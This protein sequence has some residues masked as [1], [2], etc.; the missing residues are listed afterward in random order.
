L[1]ARGK[2]EF[3]GYESLEAPARITAIIGD[4]AELE[5]LAAGAKAEVVLDQTPFYAESGGQVGDHGA[6]YSEAGEK[7][8]V[9]FETYTPVPGLSVHKVKVT[10]AMAKGDAV[11]AKV[12]PE[13]RQ[14]TM[15]NHTATHL[16]H[17]ALRKVL[18]NHVKQAGSV[19]E[20]GRLRF[21]FT[22]YTAMTPEE[23]AEVERLM[24]EN[25]LVNS[26]VSTDVMELDQAVEAGA[27]ALFGEKYAEKVRV[28]SVPGFSKELCGGTHV[29]RTGDIGMCKVVYE[30]SISAGVRR[31]EAITG[32]GALERFQ[33]ATDSLHR[34]SAALRANEPELVEQVNR[35]LSQQ[36]AL[37]KEIEQL[38]NK[39]AQ[40]QAGGL[41]DQARE[42][43]GA[44]V[45]AGR[46]DGMDRAQMRALVDTL[47]NRWKTAVVIL[48]SAEDSNVAIVGGVTKDLTKKVHAG[49]L[50]GEVAKAVGGRGGGR[51]DMAEAGGKDPGAVDGA[52]K[53]VYTAVE[54]ML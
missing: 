37:E 26:G 11:V 8:A 52:L 43:G 19:V 9:V 21:D 36:K 49:K 38:K 27:M 24:N 39:V 16:L 1:Q 50:V 41:E 48:A 32:A 17:A 53:G 12:D 23:I 3:L 51:P 34:V 14:S 10:G 25:I 45:L 7:V 40:S 15:R 20:P 42:I 46:V 35:L 33:Q 29:G 6:L 4:E 22:H 28:V 47:R 2:T 54:G 31:I 13:R 44:R 18:G 5:T 30:G